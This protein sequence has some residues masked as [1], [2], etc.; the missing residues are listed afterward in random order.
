MGGVRADLSF[1]LA[2]AL[3]VGWL[4]GGGRMLGLVHGVLDVLD[5]DYLASSAF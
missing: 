3:A 5:W 4:L 2:F 1:L